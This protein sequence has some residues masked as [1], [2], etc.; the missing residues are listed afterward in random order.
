MDDNNIA[1]SDLQEDP[2][3][4]AT[5]TPEVEPA[6]TEPEVVETPEAEPTEPDFKTNREALE[7]AFQKA[8]GEK[9][10]EPTKPEKPVD[11]PAALAPI[12]TKAPQAWK[13]ESRDKFPTLPPDVQQEVLRRENEISTTLA[14][15]AEERRVAN[16][17]HTIAS[18]YA[19]MYQARGTNAMVAAKELFNADYTLQTGTQQQKA[20]L[21]TKLI[22]Q[23]AVDL[24]TLDSTLAGVQSKEPAVDPAVEQ[25]IRQ[26]EQWAAQQ[27]QQAQ[28]SRETTLN[29]TIDKFASDPKNE[30]FNDVAPH[31]I[32]LL[33]GGAASTLEDAYDQACHA[34]P[35]VRKTLTDR[36]QANKARLKA[37]N[38]SLPNRG[39]RGQFQPATPKFKSNREALLAA[40]PDEDKRV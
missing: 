36:E 7:A 15:T 2:N 9:P 40:W 39:P 10:A 17:F 21:L 11:V 33:N 28:Q 6:S 12:T 32:A 37:A 13:P 1:T 23:Y 8:Q 38:T 34:N 27:Q 16:D 14:R 24:Q 31:M 4:F 20:D 5:E 35:N 30:F 18:P 29:S 26:M 3:H 25:R 19:A 22:K